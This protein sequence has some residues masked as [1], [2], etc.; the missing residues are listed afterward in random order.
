M[1]ERLSKALEFANYSVTLNNQRR[2]LKEKLLADVV[3]Y[4]N[5]GCFTVTKELINFVKTLVDTGN[6]Q[7][8]IMID[9]NDVPIQIENLEDFLDTI[10]NIYFTATNEYYTNYK[11][12]RINRS[13]EGIV[14]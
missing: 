14:K 7:N 13:V 8:V 9:D 11:L 2:S 3:H 5:G 1:D 12:L 10:L 4:S 6:E